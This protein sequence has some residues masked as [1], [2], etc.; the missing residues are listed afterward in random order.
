M[1]YTV[2][3]LAALEREHQIAAD[4]RHLAHLTVTGAG[5]PAASPAPLFPGVP[6]GAEFAPLPAGMSP[7]FP[8][9]TGFGEVA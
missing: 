2:D 1:R 7:L 3:Q 6:E 5:I 9:A 8:D 4:R